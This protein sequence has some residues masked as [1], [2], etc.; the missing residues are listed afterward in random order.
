[1]VSPSETVKKAGIELSEFIAATKKQEFGSH[2]QDG[3]GRASWK[4]PESGIIKINSDA[5]VSL[6]WGC[7]V[8]WIA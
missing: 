6:N 1:M 5:A 3:C 8:G 7:S 4:P 2:V